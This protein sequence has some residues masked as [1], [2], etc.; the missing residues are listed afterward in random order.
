MGQIHANEG[1]V[2]DFLFASILCPH[3][4][5]FQAQMEE[6]EDMVAHLEGCIAA[7]GASLSPSNHPFGRQ[8]P[9]P[10]ANCDGS[11]H[12]MV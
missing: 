3:P 1:K 7:D 11:H 5:E 4:W 9:A 2:E 12:L 8:P 10:K 6:G